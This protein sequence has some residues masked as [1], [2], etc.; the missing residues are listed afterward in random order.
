MVVTVQVV[1]DV[2]VLPRGTQR[3]APSP[4]I[5]RLTNEFGI[6]FRSLHSGTADPTL[7]SW[8]TVDLPDDVRGARTLDRL[9]HHP[10]IAGAFV[11]PAEAL[12]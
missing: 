10:L 5:E 8:Y 3:A 4:A 1:E 11:K 12:P 6:A 9:R 7:R 2:L